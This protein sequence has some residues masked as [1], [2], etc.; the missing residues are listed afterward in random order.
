VIL[1]PALGEAGRAVFRS[2][3]AHLL[4]AVVSK[5]LFSFLLGAV[6]AVLA[7]LASLEGL[8][9]WTQ[10]LLMSAFWWGAYLRRHEAL[11]V[12]GGALA[13]ERT[14]GS[15]PAA[16]RLER[17]LA[18]PRRAL[19]SAHALKSRMSKP[20]PDAEHGVTVARKERERA[21]SGA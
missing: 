1:A 18:P 9:W 16:R 7:I 10:W 19:R 21:P 15:R 5:L 3:A 17:A 11:G 14:P 13:T 20:A 2:W 6:L 4:A 12:A 8:G